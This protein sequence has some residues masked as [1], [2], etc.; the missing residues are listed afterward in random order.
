MAL[1]LT[2]LL[3][4]IEEVPSLR[5]LFTG[6]Q[7]GAPVVVSVLE[8]ARAFLIAAVSRKLQVPVLVVTGQPEKAKHLYE[9]IMIWCPGSNVKL[10]PESEFLPYERLATD[11]IT[12]IERLQVLAALAG[13]SNSGR[14]TG[15][16]T[17]PLLVIASA[18]ALLPKTISPHDLNAASH[19]IKTGMAA[20]PFDLIA[21]W[22][23][24]GYRVEAAVDVPGTV[25]HRGGIIDIYPLHEDNPARIE[26]FGNTIDSIRIFDPASQ[27]S[28][29]TVPAVRITPA[30]ELPALTPS[31]LDNLHKLDLAGLDEDYRQQL[32][33]DFIDLSSGVGGNP[34]IRQ[35]YGPFLNRHSLLDYFSGNALVV[36]DEPETFDGALEGLE[37]EIHELKAEKVKQH[38]LPAEF[39]LPAFLRS[40]IQEILSR[41]RTLSLAEWG[42]DVGRQEL[43]FKSAPGYAGQISSFI[44]KLREMITRKNRVIVI[45][46][47]ASRLSELLEEQGMTAPVLSEIK[48]LPSLSSLALVQGLLGEGWVLN[49]QT[50]LF[51]DT[52]IFGFTKQR[53]LLRRRPVP[54]HKLSIDITPGNYVVHVEHGIGKLNGVITMA[55]RDGEKEYLVLEY[56]A[57][58]KLYVPADQ[59]DRVSRYIGSGDH[60]PALSRLGTQD[61]ARTKQKVNEA[62]EKVAKELLAL[63]A[64]R[65]VV[66]G[67][68]FSRDTLW[69]QELEASFPYVET[70]DQLTVQSEV[71]ADMEKTKP[72]DRLVC[73]DVGYGKT[74]IAVRAAF[75]AVM[76]HK[77]VAVLVPTTV[78]AEQ[79]F[80]TFSQRFSTFPIRVEVLSRFR[81][82]RQQ[83]KI[84]DGLADGTVDVCIGTHRLIQKDVSFKNL[85]LLIIDEEQ[86]FGVAHKEFLKKIR[87]EVD[88]L[89]LSATPIPRTLHMSLVGVRDMSVMETPPEDRQPVKT[90]V[91]AYDDRLVREAISRE[92]ERNGQAFFLH[93]RVQSIDFVASKLQML[94][95]EARIVVGHGQ[96]DE[97]QLNQV[98]ID[99][100]QGKADVLVCTTI[101]ESGLDMPN[102]NTLIVNQADRF[103]LSQLYQLRGRIGRG[104]N[105][106]YAYFLYD[107]GKHLTELAE[108]RLQTIYEATELGAGFGIAMKDLEIRGAGNLLGVH[109]SGHISAVGFSLYTQLLARAVDELKA[110][111]AGIPE[112]KVKEAHL[113]PPTIDLPMPAYIPEDYVEDLNSR[114]AL[115]QKLV[116]LEKV[117]GIDLLRQEFSDR[118]GPL[119][120]ELENL[121]YAVKIKLLASRVHLES[122][123][124]DEGEIVLRRFEGMRF[125]REKMEPFLRGLRLPLGSL[126]F[127][128]LAVRVHPKRIGDTWPQVLEEVIRRVA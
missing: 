110:K 15:H 42:V 80:V 13:F 31:R 5:G 124:L 56:A 6:M 61:W 55:T 20:V 82:H 122:V 63:Y 92:L 35:F 85:G 123:G 84:L 70:P 81:T 9:Q 75:K 65:E 95:P 104:A 40:E 115:Y 4:L 83:E 107:K 43:P 91:A 36:I 97:E 23:S 112:E 114:I 105:T 66:P 101:I 98:M 87:H 41:R 2:N 14:P 67:Y 54:R 16:P 57:G 111:Q 117:A 18:A 96:M 19:E 32:E 34:N 39:P 27:R 68:A 50:Y 37:N 119:P 73:G 17:E 46:N 127:D 44:Q 24:I 51:T 113:P 71:K 53:R 118:F 29:R 38:K 22:Q 74:E 109:Q 121:L 47:Q 125:S 62:V 100:V 126:H 106:A 93:N 58:D 99:F 60:A 49:D 1:D 8:S 52:E 69:Q 76:D 30:T 64:T 11:N 33:N 28:L 116:R 79:H 45:S 94:V 3:P 86:R 102:V 26:F 25:S 120:R 103:G 59:I 108:K 72:M 89:A 78:L 21:R 77:Q 7:K 48:Q 88:V 12:E 90:F 128:P 10:F